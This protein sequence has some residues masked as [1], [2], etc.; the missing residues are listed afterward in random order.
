MIAA[1]ISFCWLFYELIVMISCCLPLQITT[2]IVEFN[3]PRSQ[4]AAACLLPNTCLGIAVQIFTK[5]EAAQVGVTWKNFAD[6]PTADD[7]FSLALV[8]LMMIV[9]C[10]VCW[11]LTW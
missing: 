8:W 6:P 5:L 2:Y 3:L 9:Q 1:N 11:I 4:K 7:N 10:L